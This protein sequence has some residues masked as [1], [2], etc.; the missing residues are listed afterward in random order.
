MSCLYD[1]FFNPVSSILIIWKQCLQSY[2]LNFPPQCFDRRSPVA[3]LYIF[4]I[5]SV[6]IGLVIEL[7]HWLEEIRLSVAL[8]APL[9]FFIPSCELQWHNNNIFIS[10][11]NIQYIE[12]SEIICYLQIRA[13]PLHVFARRDW[14]TWADLIIS[15]ECRPWFDPPAPLPPA[16]ASQQLFIWLYS[17]NNAHSHE[18]IHTQSPVWLQLRW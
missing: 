7:L 13:E 10:P 6:K 11:V 9:H 5:N 17:I 12:Q 18:H 2:L 16:W 3:S 8:P 4:F 15:H 1:Q 14:V